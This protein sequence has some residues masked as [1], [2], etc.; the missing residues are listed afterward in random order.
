M[1]SMRVAAA[2]ADPRRAVPAANTEVDGEQAVESA[3][4]NHDALDDRQRAPNVA[5]SVKSP[6]WMRTLPTRDSDGD[7]RVEE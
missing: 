7:T 3:A 1:A 5:W 2:G 6:S 4:L